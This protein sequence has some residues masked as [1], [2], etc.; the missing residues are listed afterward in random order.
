MTAELTTIRRSCA[1]ICWDSAVEPTT[2]QNSTHICVRPSLR[3]ALLQ[4][5][6]ASPQPLYK[7]AATWFAKPCGCQFTGCP[8]ARNPCCD[9]RAKPRSHRKGSR[10]RTP[11]GRPDLTWKR[12][13]NREPIAP[14]LGVER[15]LGLWLGRACLDI[16]LPLM[17][18][19]V[20]ARGGRD[21]IYGP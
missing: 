6:S 3:S 16:A 7:R 10:W 17:M 20:S 8:L 21:S 15:V 19:G 9:A 14:P 4:A 13:A 5:L 1:S 12:A 11:Q 18:Q 2:S